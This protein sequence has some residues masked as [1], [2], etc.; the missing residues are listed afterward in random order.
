VQAVFL[1]EVHR[2]GGGG[3]FAGGHQGGVALAPVV[4]LGLEAL[5]VGLGVAGGPALRFGVG[6]GAAPALFGLFGVLLGVLVAEDLEAF[7]GGEV[8]AH[9]ACLHGVFH[10][11]GHSSCTTS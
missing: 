6:L 8:D 7:L 5:P 10:G 9:S 4:D 3:G 11:L 2:R 1:G